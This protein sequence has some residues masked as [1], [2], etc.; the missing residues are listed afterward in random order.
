M[1]RGSTFEVR[2]KNE[3]EAPSEPTSSFSPR[4]SNLEPRWIRLYALVLT[5]LA[6]TIAVFYA[7]TKIFQ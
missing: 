7:F 5:E 4:T 3:E 2:M 1:R 6:L